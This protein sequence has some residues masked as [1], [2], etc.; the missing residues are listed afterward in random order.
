MKKNVAL[1]IKSSQY[2]EDL[3]PSGKAFSR[4]LELED[5]I[6]ILTEGT[7]YSK[8]NTTYITYEESEEAGLADI[9]TMLK[10]IPAGEGKDPT[11]HIHRYSRN[12]DN[13]DTNMI[14]Q[15]GV[16]N[17]TRY[18]IPKLASLDLEVYT[19]KLEENL[20]EDGYGKISVDYRIKFDQYYSRRNKLEIEVKRD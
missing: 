10:L 1:K 4:E 8:D 12:D 6:E 15:Q 20:D 19:N 16:R 11:L 2:V 5:S 7:L 17:I 13:D 14:L 18:R 9:L 3:K